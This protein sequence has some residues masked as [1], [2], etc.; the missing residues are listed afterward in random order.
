MRKRVPYLAIVQ[1]LVLLAGSHLARGEDLKDFYS[2]LA[3][4]AE[5]EVGVFLNGTSFSGFSQL[6]SVFNSEAALEQFSTQIADQ[7]NYY[8]VG[9]TVAGFTYKFDPNLNIFER[10]TD[11]LGPLLSERGQTTGQGKLNVAFGYSWID[12]DD[13]QGQNLGNY[14]LTSGGA[15]VIVITPSPNNKISGPTPVVPPSVFVPPP[16][17]VVFDSGLIS[18]GKGLIHFVIPSC[19]SSSCKAAGGFPASGTP[20]SYT[21]LASIPNVTL[22]TSIETDAYALFVNYGVTDKLDVGIVVPYLATYLKG[23]VQA[24]GLIDPSTG[25]AFSV[26]TSGSAQSSGIGDLVLRAK[27]NFFDGEYGALASRLDFYVPTGNAD[28]FQGFGHP[29]AGGSLIY[30]AAI[31]P[32]SPHASVAFLWRFD[33]QQFNEMRFSLGGDLRVTQWLTATTDF[34]L[35]QNTAQYNIGNTI[36]AASTGIKFN[37]WRRLVLSTNLLWRLNDQGLRALVI[38]SVSVEYTFR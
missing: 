8:P 34:L 31:G 37:P 17:S 26:Q 25:R 15:P 32:F 7:F 11:G 3:A 20:G 38:P 27:M 13:F 21:L 24:T 12:Y 23:N 29:A 10:S 2:S 16:P 1:V 30:S 36:L 18:V 22:D 9:S 33:A 35:N 28:N 5:T 19:G 14:N 4:Q 6:S